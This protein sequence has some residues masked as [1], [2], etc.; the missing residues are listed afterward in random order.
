[1]T[2]FPVDSIQDSMTFPEF[3]TLTEKLVAE[4][5]TTGENQGETYLEATRMNL[6]RMK[7]LTRKNRLLPE[8]QAILEGIDRPMIWVALVE[9]WCGD[10]GQI[11]PI[12]HQMAETSAQISLKLIL[13]DEYL[14]IMDAFLTN[15]ARSIPQIV[16]IDQESNEVLG[17]WGPRPHEVQEMVM[18]TKV[19]MKD[20]GTPEE[21]KAIYD[22]AKEEVQR[23]YAHDKTRGIQGEFIQ[24]LQEALQKVSM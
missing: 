13:R 10:V 21:R 23:W 14:D 1:M 22:V 7:R 8:T 11:L 2:H 4:N 15:G 19:K 5:K 3:Y 9:A 16:F 20:L 12:I 6:A 24:G 18:D 17:N